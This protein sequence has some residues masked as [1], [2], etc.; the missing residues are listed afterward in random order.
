MQTDSSLNDDKLLLEELFS[1][2]Q[3]AGRVFLDRFG[4]LIHA[5]VRS[6]T[7]RSK[8]VDHEDLFMEALGHLFEDEC[9]VLK[10]FKWSCKFSAFLYLVSRRFVLDKITREN[11]QS[12]ANV[13]EIN[14]DSLFLDSSDDS[15]DIIFSDEQRSSFNE[16]FEKL[17]PKD[18]LLSGCL[19]WKNSQLR[20][21]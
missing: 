4:G 2:K 13:Y 14:I 19:F 21:S 3:R 10:S 17:D 11:K 6:V 7:I 9:K 12:S 1:G 18:A 16:A 5:A 8:T 15:E 20:M